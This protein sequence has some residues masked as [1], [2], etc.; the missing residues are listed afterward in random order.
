MID[1]TAF[2]ET[3]RAIDQP[4]FLTERAYR[5]IAGDDRYAVWW[6]F[7]RWQEAMCHAV[8]AEDRQP[9]DALALH[10]ALWFWFR[11][12]IPIPSTIVVSGYQ[13]DLTADRLTIDL[14]A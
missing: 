8:S 14:A 5:S 11:G 12:R 1:V 7:D 13:Y 4:V 2:V 3:H 6:I 10:E 9:D